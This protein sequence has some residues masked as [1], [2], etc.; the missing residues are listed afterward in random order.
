MGCKIIHHF[1]LLENLKISKKKVAGEQPPKLS[2]DFFHTNLVGFLKIQT[3]I[4]SHSLNYTRGLKLG[5]FN[6]FDILFSISHILKVYA[7]H[8]CVKGK[9]H[10]S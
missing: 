5:H 3:I 9:L 4:K 1:E 8:N 2:S 10:D 6:I 7:L